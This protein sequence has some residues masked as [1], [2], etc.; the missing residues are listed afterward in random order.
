VISN[1][2]SAADTANIIDRVI[3]NRFMSTAKAPRRACAQKGATERS[4]KKA[5]V[6]AMMERV[7]G[8]STV[9]SGF[10]LRRPHWGKRDQ[11]K[12]LLPK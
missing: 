11:H 1:A 6:I 8:A 10:F 3:G 5:E 9:P 2:A 7:K 4:N 12:A